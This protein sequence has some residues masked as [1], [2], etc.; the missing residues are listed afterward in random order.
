[1]TF[2]LAI[3]GSF[4]GTILALLAWAR[5]TRKPPALVEAE[6]VEAAIADL[7]GMKP[8]DESVG[9]VPDPTD[10][11]YEAMTRPAWT[12]FVAKIKNRSKDAA[13]ARRAA[14]PPDIIQ[15]E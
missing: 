2:L 7:V 9:F 1:M 8:M 13:R 3:A 5:F 14:E 6:D 12:A 4:A 15:D 10:D 11:E